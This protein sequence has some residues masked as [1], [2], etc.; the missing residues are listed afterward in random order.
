MRGMRRIESSW[1]DERGFVVQWTAVERGAGVEARGR[2]DVRVDVRRL[3]EQPIE[4]ARQRIAQVQPD[5][6][7]RV[8]SIQAIG[9]DMK[10][11]RAENGRIIRRRADAERR[12]A[13][14]QP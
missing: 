11:E 1:L 4:C 14:K 2:G 9:V 3:R 12:Q 7:A 6:E 8:A 13:A 10:Q 5:V